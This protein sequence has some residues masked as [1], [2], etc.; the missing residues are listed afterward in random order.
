M[1][2]PLD[3]RPGDVWKTR[4][5]QTL[6]IGDTTRK[7]LFNRAFDIPAEYVDS[8][9]TVRP[10]VWL[11]KQGRFLGEADHYLDLVELVTR[12]RLG[13]M[14]PPE[15]STGQA[16]EARESFEHV[17]D[18][19]LY[20]GDAALYLAEMNTDR[21]QISA[22]ACVPE[23]SFA[24]VDGYGPLAR[25]L[26]DAYEQSAAGKG[27]ERHA[28]GRPFV[29]QPIIEIGRMLSSTCDGQLYQAIKKAQE[30]SGMIDR[31]DFDAAERELLG[32][33]VYLAAA[34]LLIREKRNA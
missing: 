20:T 16:D 26:E 1:S 11:N 21:E 18:A 15:A 3:I 7:P 9:S 6:R 32:G 2:G 8:A 31:G 23:P 12:E 33:I 27:K 34:V 24:P 4:V 13:P 17:A 22:L 28:N 29:K 10:T 25:V 14:D 30:A 5:G 19:S